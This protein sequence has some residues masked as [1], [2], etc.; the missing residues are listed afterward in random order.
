MSRITRIMLIALS[1]VIVHGI[2]LY[3]VVE[4]GKQCDTQVTFTDGE[5]RECRDVSSFD[6]GMSRIRLCDG[7]SIDVP[8]VRIKEVIK[9]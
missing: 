6:N 2:V 1:I 3:F 7:T 5:S 4:E 9:K 8:T